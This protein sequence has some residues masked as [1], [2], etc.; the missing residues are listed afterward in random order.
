[1]ATVVVIVD[2]RGRLALVR[3]VS[4]RSASVIRMG[5]AYVNVR[6]SRHL[7]VKAGLGYR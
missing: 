6:V 2:G 5:V 3:V 7:K 4:R 1:M